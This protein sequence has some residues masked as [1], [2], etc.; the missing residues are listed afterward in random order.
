MIRGEPNILKFFGPKW[1]T[2]V[3]QNAKNVLPVKPYVLMEKYTLFLQ[4]LAKLSKK[5]PCG[6]NVTSLKALLHQ[7]LQLV[8][9]DLPWLM[10]PW[11]LQKLKKC[12]PSF[13]FQVLDKNSGSLVALCH[14]L[15]ASLHLEL[16]NNANHLKVQELQTVPEAQDTMS[17]TLL[18]SYTLLLSKLYVVKPRFR[19]FESGP[20]VYYLIKNKSCEQSGQLKVRTIYSYA[21]HPCK[22]LRKLAGRALNQFLKHAIQSLPTWEIYN[23]TD[24]KQW[25]LSQQSLI[26]EYQVTNSLPL[27]GSLVELHVKDM[28][29]GG[30]DCQTSRPASR[31]L[32]VPFLVILGPPYFLGVLEMAEMV[33]FSHRV[34]HQ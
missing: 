14:K 18:H 2:V 27:M 30:S 20:Y 17:N 10:K 21:S 15:S 3:L 23:L 7:S 26:Q 32:N 24:V 11:T 31:L 5:G 16:G 12:F 34:F 28:F 22:T 6:A 25:I 9:H 13:A 4:G 1:S 33:D 8:E 29:L 19:P